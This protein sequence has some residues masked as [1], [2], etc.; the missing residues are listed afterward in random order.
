M[1]LIPKQMVGAT[2]LGHQ[3]ATTYA[4]YEGIS[5]QAYLERMGTPLLTP[6]MVGRSVVSLLTEEAYQ[7][8][9]AFSVSS[10][11]VVPVS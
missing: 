10:Q 9:L 11:E 1:V 4:A 7:N 3:A 5:E 6:E 2:E 8:S